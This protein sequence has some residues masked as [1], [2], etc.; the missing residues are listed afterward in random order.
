MQ[1]GVSTE[2]LMRHVWGEGV[3]SSSKRL[4]ASRAISLKE[5]ARLPLSLTLPPLNDV[6]QEREGEVRVKCQFARSLMSLLLDA[7]EESTGKRATGDVPPT[8]PQTYPPPH[9][10]HPPLSDDTT[11]VNALTCETRVL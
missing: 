4:L 3:T 11:L 9:P 10:T 6:N 8:P 5:F 1:I 7:R 2:L